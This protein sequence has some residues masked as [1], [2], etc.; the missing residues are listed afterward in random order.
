MESKVLLIL[1]V[2][3]IE[4]FETVNLQRCS[5]LIQSFHPSQYMLLKFITCSF[6]LPLLVNSWTEWSKC[7]NQSERFQLKW[8]TQLI[9]FVCFSAF[10]DYSHVYTTLSALLLTWLASFITLL[11]IKYPYFHSKDNP[12]GLLQT[13][14]NT[15]LIWRAA[16]QN[17]C[18]M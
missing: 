5:G 18:L 17:A 11:Q 14:E 10:R 2:L 1:K 16:P 3:L 7:L 12:T 6:G 9:R 8:L 4:R 13:S 15:P